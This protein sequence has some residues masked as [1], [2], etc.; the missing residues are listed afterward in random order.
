VVESLTGL[1]VDD[2]VKHLNPSASGNGG[3]PKTPPSP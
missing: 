2:L 3:D 1:R